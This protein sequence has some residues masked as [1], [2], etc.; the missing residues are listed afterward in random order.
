MPGTP[1]DIAQQARH[2]SV[3][4]VPD[5]HDLVS[6][7]LAILHDCQSDSLYKVRLASAKSA[8]RSNRKRDWHDSITLYSSIGGIEAGFQSCKAAMVTCV[9]PPKLCR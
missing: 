6:F 1:L 2:I 4:P 9:Q 3:G 5:A 8:T 7:D